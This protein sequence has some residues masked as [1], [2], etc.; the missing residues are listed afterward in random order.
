MT[1][2]YDEE[3]KSCFFSQLLRF[4]VLCEKKDKSLSQK[5]L[6]GTISWSLLVLVVTSIVCIACGGTETSLRAVKCHCL[7]NGFAHICC[8]TNHQYLFTFLLWNGTWDYRVLQTWQ[9]KWLFLSLQQTFARISLVAWWVQLW[10][11]EYKSEWNR[12][13]VMFVFIIHNLAIF[14]K[15]L[16]R[17]DH[18]S[19][20]MH[21]V[22]WCLASLSPIVSMS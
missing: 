17:D 16:F 2:I 21:I 5:I 22:Y 15:C 14:L 19:R 1:C 8:K 4:G 9:N 12:K 7:R 6:D 10:G 11:Q 18:Q 3:N 20:M 13:A